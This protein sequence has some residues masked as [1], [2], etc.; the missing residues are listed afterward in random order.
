MTAAPKSIAGLMDEAYLVL[1]RDDLGV[2]HAEHLFQRVLDILKEDADAREWFLRRS[3]EEII[4]GPQ[5]FCLPFPTRRPADFVDDALMCYVAHATRWKEF[6]EAC[7][8]RMLSKAYLEKF[9]GC[10]DFADDVMKA[11]SDDWEDRD[12][13]RLFTE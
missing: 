7:R 5:A 8:V 9:S 11:L 6:A 1:Y 2:N 3:A 4:S 10:C 12:F 13:Y